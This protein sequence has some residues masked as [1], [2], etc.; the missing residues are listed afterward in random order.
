MGEAH[1]PYSADW[2]SDSASHNTRDTDVM[3]QGIPAGESGRPPVERPEGAHPSGEDEPELNLASS[4][5]LGD[6]G[7]KE[8]P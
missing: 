2:G 1:W 3:A 5:R 6:H 7:N 4:T 8:N